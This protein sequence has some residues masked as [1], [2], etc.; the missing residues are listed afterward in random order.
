[1]THIVLASRKPNVI[2]NT[3]S[4]RQ[5]FSQGQRSADKNSINLNGQKQRWKH[6]KYVLSDKSKI[7]LTADSLACHVSLSQSLTCRPKALSPY[8]EQTAA[9]LIAY[10]LRPCALFSGS[11]EQH[12]FNNNLSLSTVKMCVR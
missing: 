10:R 3:L 11:A 2:I 6:P 1:M 5:H 9:R 4:V 7:Q 8:N 12:R